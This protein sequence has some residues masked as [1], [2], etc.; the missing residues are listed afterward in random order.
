VPASKI[1]AP[2]GGLGI[3]RGG[4][5]IKEG[6]SMTVTPAVGSGGGN[7]VP[8]A[9]G[10]PKSGSAGGCSMNPNRET[11]LAEGVA[12]FTLLGLFAVRRLR[13]Q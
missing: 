9:A 2:P 1:C 11:S 10:A 5:T 6:G 13:R 12:L 7:P 3:A 4:D 8:P